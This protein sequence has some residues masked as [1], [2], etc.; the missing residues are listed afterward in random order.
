MLR[1]IENLFMLMALSL[2]YVH[3]FDLVYTNLS[4]VINHIF[5][6]YGI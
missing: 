6:F 3:R 1:I 2:W 5:R 4:W